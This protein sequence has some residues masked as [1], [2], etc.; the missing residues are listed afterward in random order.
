MTDRHKITPYPLRLDPEFRAQ[1]EKAAKSSGRSL[2][3]E[4]VTRL[5]NSFDN[6]HGDEQS[7]AVGIKL[8]LMISE[9]AMNR[10]LKSGDGGLDYSLYL[11]EIERLKSVDSEL[12]GVIEHIMSAPP[13]RSELSTYDKPADY[14]TNPDP[15]K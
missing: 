7:M 5:E 3:A 12:D 4:I 11:K 14:K 8:G 10:A 2:H 15:E 6:K 9:T 13:V 1:I